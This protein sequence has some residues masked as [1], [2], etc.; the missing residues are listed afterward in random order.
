MIYCIS[1]PVVSNALQ[2]KVDNHMILSSC[3]MSISSF[4][5]HRKGTVGLPSF[6]KEN[7]NDILIVHL[8]FVCSLAHSSTLPLRQGILIKTKVSPC[9]INNN[10]TA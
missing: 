6:I 10:I 3:T 5:R 1:V 8:G 7:K 9:K 2:V 4:C